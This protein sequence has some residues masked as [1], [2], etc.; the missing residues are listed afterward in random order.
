MSGYEAAVTLIA[1]VSVACLVVVVVR[2][3]SRWAR[4][5]RRAWHDIWHRW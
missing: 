3:I 4:V 2:K 5:S 1:V